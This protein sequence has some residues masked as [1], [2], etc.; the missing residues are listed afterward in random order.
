V[1]REASVGI[2][3]TDLAIDDAESGVGNLR[4]DSDRLAKE[5]DV[6]VTSARESAAGEF[7]DIPICAKI[8]SVLDRGEITRS[9]GIDPVN[10]A[11]GG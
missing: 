1:K 9:V 8:D 7:Y 4:P 5:I 2:A 11:E 6:P 3:R 10:R